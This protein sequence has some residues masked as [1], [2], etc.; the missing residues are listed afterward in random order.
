MFMYI[1]LVGLVAL[2]LFG[3]YQVLETRTVCVCLLSAALFLMLTALYVCFFLYVRS[4]AADGIE[5]T[6]AGR[7]QPPPCEI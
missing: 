3:M 7:V 1:F 5:C 4:T 2:M 6:S